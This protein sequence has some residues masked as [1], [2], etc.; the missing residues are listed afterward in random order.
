MFTQFINTLLAL[1]TFAFD[2]STVSHVTPRTIPTQSSLTHCFMYNFPF[3]T[4]PGRG[5]SDLSSKFGFFAASV[6]QLYLYCRAGSRL[7]E[8][9]STKLTSV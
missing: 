2:V 5:D 7:T 6:F 1:C 3:Q 4:K 8:L 9:V